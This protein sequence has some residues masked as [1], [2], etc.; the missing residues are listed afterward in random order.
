MNNWLHPYTCCTHHTLQQKA[1]QT[2]Q[3]TGTHTNK[4]QTP[5][6]SFFFSSSSA[7][8]LRSIFISLFFFDVIMFTRCT[9]ICTAH[10]IKRVVNTRKIEKLTRKAARPWAWLS[11]NSARMWSPLCVRLCAVCTDQFCRFDSKSVDCD[12]MH[13]MIT[14][15]NKEQCRLIVAKEMHIENSQKRRKAKIVKWLS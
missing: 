15:L 10:K 6:S 7:I 11:A 4:Q 1:E 9:A 12:Q 5:D 3:T 8:F 14:N 2:K 13:T